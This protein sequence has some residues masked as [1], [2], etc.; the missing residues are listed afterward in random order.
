MMRRVD[1]RGGSDVVK[2]KKTAED[3]EFA[4]HQPGRS[5]I[6]RSI[7]LS[8]RVFRSVPRPAPGPNM[9]TIMPSGVTIA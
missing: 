6:I 3:R 9:C 5:A 8:F 1:V 4:L 2:V 7:P